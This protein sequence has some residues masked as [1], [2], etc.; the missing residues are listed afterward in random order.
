M[1][2]NYATTQKLV[3]AELKQTYGVRTFEKPIR[4][5]R[6]RSLNHKLNRKL[7]LCMHCVAS[8]RAEAARKRGAK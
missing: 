8:D 6:C 5:G 3:A 7:G 4:C 2:A 1:T